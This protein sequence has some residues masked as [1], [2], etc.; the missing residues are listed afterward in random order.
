MLFH[1]LGDSTR[2]TIMCALLREGEMCVGEVHAELNVSMSATSQHLR[3]L[4]SRGL[5]YSKRDG[6]RVCY[7]PQH[8]NAFIAHFSEIFN[9][10]KE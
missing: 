8:D 1:T 2:L 9:I 6:Q 4:E 3:L 10:E 7:F 5:A